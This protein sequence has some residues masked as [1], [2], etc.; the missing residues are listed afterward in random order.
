M[1]RSHQEPE[2]NRH[3]LRRWLLSSMLWKP[4][5]HS[6]FGLHNKLL[7]KWLLQRYYAKRN[8]PSAINAFHPVPTCYDGVRNQDETDIDCGGDNCG[9]CWVNQT[10]ADDCDCRIRSCISGTCRGNISKRLFLMHITRSICWITRAFMRWWS[11]EPRRN[12]HRLWRS[13]LWGM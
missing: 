11:E 6:T 4:T 13:S 7:W 3:R 10:C 9:R 5:L 8:W 12:W 1:R 2:R